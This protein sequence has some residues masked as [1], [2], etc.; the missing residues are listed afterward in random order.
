MKLS[1]AQLI[2]SVAAYVAA[3]NISVDTFAATANNSVGLLDT[4][5]KI[6][7]LQSNYVDKLEMFNAEDLS[8]GK[9]VEEWKSDLKLAEDYDNTGAGA[10][11]PHRGTYRPVSF[12][13]TLGRKKIP[14]TIDY[15][16]VERAVHN[17]EQ[18]AEIIADKYKVITDSEVVYKYAIKRQALGLLIGRC[19]YN[20]D[21]TNATSWTD[22]NHTNIGG[23]YKYGSPVVVGTLVK[24]YTAGDA[25][26][27]D[28]AIAKGFIIV[29]QLTEEVPVPVDTT[30]GEDF[31]KA[32]KKDVEISEDM[33]EGHSLN[34]NTLGVSP[35]GL[36]LIIKQGVM[37][38]IETDVLA[39]A[40]HED[41]V[42]TPVEIIRVPD[43]GSYTG[44]A[45]AL[46][47]DKRGM[48]LFNTYRA[49]R[50]NVNGDGDWLNL[51]AHFEYTCHISKNT[52]VKAY[53]D[54]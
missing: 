6:F 12:S 21:A 23:L 26:S 16:D 46:L 50:E 5:S 27:F 15:N 38:V 30:T 36:V 42:A 13:F 7:T 19:V 18:F 49:V 52:F 24:A 32:L 54:D 40:F 3:A 20:M 2:A 35:A 9:T 10:L 33:S 1:R 29:N 4:V 22:A 47:M 31:I 48:K 51:F 28:D 53:L 37:P 41:R 14:Q 34:Q 8:Y 45:Y 44:K 43:F 17:A 11:S 25:S 39:G